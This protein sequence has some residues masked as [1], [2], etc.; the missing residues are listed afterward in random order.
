MVLNQRSMLVAKYQDHHA[1]TDIDETDA[2]DDNLV[3]VTARTVSGPES[4]KYLQCFTIFSNK[5]KLSQQ[6]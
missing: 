3:I 5:A 1:A 2:E 6:F 4:N